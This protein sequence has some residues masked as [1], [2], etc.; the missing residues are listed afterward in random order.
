MSIGKLRIKL[1][2]FSNILVIHQFT[3][4][5]KLYT[6]AISSEIQKRWLQL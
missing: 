1:N 4:L 3:I 5:N 2:P 6:K